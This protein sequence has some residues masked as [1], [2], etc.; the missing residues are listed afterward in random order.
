MSQLSVFRGLGDLKVA[1][2]KNSPALFEAI[3][4]TRLKQKQE[5]LAIPKWMDKRSESGE[6]LVEPAG[7]VD[8]YS[9]PL[10]STGAGRLVLSL[11]YKAF[12]AVTLGLAV[13]LVA[14]FWLGRVTGPASPSEAEK[15]GLPP[16]N[17]KV[18]NIAEKAPKSPAAKPAGNSRVPGKHYLIIESLAGVSDTDRADAGRILS[19]LASRGEQADIG[20]TRVG[21]KD[22]F[23]I[24]SLR[25]MDKPASAEAIAYAKKI[26]RMGKQY[27]AQ[28]GK[29]R[30]QQRRSPSAKLEP[31]YRTVQLKQ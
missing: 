16:I 23:V 26:E 30:F 11:D 28:H 3:S 7:I 20:K 5:N 21:G 4:K 2:K 18:L 31:Y 19:F 22:V 1:R 8:N 17:T 12:L 15:A 10:I 25:P 27:L 14:A 13:L 24:W 29:Y 6:A 9:G